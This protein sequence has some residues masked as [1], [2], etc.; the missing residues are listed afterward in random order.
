MI[1]AFCTLALASCVKESETEAPQEMA[2][3]VYN[4][5]FYDYE[6]RSLG[7]ASD[8][9]HIWYAV[10][11]EDGSL[12]YECEAPAEI[13]GGNAEC[14]VTLI[15]E[16]SYRVVFLGMHYDEDMNPSYA[17]DAAAAVV[18]QTEH[19]YANSDKGDLFYT[20][21]DVNSYN[22]NVSDGVSLD[23]ITAQVNFICNAADWT[24]AQQK[25]VASSLELSGVPA[26]YSLLEGKAVAETEKVTYPKTALP[27][28]ND[29]E[30][31]GGYAVF[32]AYTFAEAEPQ[33]TRAAAVLKMWNEGTQ[34]EEDYL[35]NV[36]GADLSENKT[37]NINGNLLSQGKK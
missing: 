25:P 14:P 22:G 21:D 5:A 36:A 11:N 32:S 37:T 16:K 7:D 20:Y 6:I 9:N 35:I 19:P 15:L 8:I 12:F 13:L 26:A 10:Y 31:N 24:S 29:L 34:G 1:V 17:I 23:R 2:T 18:R 28:G 3:A 4:V 33:T 30:M 27:T